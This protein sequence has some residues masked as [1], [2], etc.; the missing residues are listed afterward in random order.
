TDNVGKELV[1]F[2]TYWTK[3]FFV[4]RI[5]VS[6]GVMVIVTISA[7]ADVKVPRIFSDHMVLQREIPVVVWG[8]ADLE[9]KV[10]VKFGEAQVDGTPDAMRRWTVKLPALKACPTGKD[11]TITGK[12]T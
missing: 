9:E 3:E 12:N 5:M 10:T 6:L 11:L 4:K 7:H 8:V 1:F 2:W